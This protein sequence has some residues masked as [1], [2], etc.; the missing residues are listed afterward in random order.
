MTAVTDVIVVGGG[1]SGLTT[2]MVLAEGGHRVRVWS[3]E[4]AA[5]TTSAVAGALWWP[6]RIEPEAL[7]GDWALET[8]REYEEL[9]AAP[10]ETGVRLVAGCT[11]VSGSPRS[12]RGCTGSRA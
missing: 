7:V 5:A 8:L 9:S 10:E 1:V 2:A 3:R 6:Y 4:P 12:D 11:G